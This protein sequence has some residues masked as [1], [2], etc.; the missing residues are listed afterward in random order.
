[1][2]TVTPRAQEKLREILESQGCPQAPVR[3]AVV[4]GPHGCIHGWELSLEGEEGPDD[5]VVEAG[6]VRIL[7]EPD[8]V[9]MVRGACIDYR[10]DSTVIGFTIDTPNAPPPG[11]GHGGGCGHHH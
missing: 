5:T 11:H 8:L 7:V 2:L 4:R 1:M 10:E 9:E 3:L 6:P